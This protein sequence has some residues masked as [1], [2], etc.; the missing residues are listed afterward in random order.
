MTDEIIAAEPHIEDT[1]SNHF[2]AEPAEP[3]TAADRLRAFEDEHFGE[4]CVRINGLIERGS[5]SPYAAKPELHAQYA[6]LQRL[7]ETEQQLAD[8]HAALMVADDN[9]QA[10]LAAVE[11]PDASP[12]E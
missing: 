2:E 1:A 4:K 8:A 5:G 7:I 12:A 10:A 6:A 9:H 11:N 3:M